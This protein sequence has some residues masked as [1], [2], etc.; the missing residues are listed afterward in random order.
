MENGATLFTLTIIILIEESHS[1]KPIPAS[2]RM[3]C[4][5]MSVIDR[6]GKAAVFL[7]ATPKLRL[8]SKNIKRLLK[9]AIS[10]SLSF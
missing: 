9:K 7:R 4:V 3:F 1:F 5:Q 10:R 8:Y 2:I 6:R